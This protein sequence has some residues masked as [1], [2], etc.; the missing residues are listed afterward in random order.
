[1][2][3]QEQIDRL[4]FDA[5]AN[6]RITDA[7]ENTQYMMSGEGFVRYE[8]PNTLTVY[9]EWDDNGYTASLRAYTKQG[10]KEHNIS[11]KR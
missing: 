8:H 11:I 7:V 4:G 5:W 9:I 6:C 3:P 1:M 10:W 2:I